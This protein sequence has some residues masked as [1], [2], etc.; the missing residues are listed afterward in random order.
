M[1]LRRTPRES[2]IMAQAG[3]TGAV[4]V[5]TNMAGR[6]TDILLGGCPKT[7]ARIKTRSSMVANGV[8]TYEEAEKLPPIASRRP[9][10]LSIGQ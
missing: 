7:M 6:G 8:L 3:R 1:H 5:A 4:T 10:S 2:E 9:L